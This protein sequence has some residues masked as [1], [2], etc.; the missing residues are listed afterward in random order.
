MAKSNARF[1]ADDFVHRLE[2]DTDFLSGPVE[3]L[4]DRQVPHF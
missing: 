3:F 4:D 1:L 2:Q